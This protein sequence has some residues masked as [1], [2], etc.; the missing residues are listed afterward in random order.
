MINYNLLSRAVKEPQ[1]FKDIVSERLELKRLGK[2][3]EQA[4]LKVVI[5]NWCQL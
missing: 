3:K 5:R 2:K 4:P 1:K